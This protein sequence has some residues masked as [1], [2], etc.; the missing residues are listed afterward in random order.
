MSRY[1]VEAKNLE[2]TKHLIIWD[3]ESTIVSSK[4]PNSL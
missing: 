1:I 4:D 3:G 2:V